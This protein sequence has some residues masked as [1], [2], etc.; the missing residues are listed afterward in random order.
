MR[1]QN[2]LPH[3]NSFDPAQK[4]VRRLDGFHDKKEWRRNAPEPENSRRWREEERETGLLGRKDR[5]KEG[6]EYRKSD[7]RTDNASV[8]EAS[9][10][11]AL[12]SSDRWHDVNSRSS[13]HDSRRDSKWSSRWGPEDRDKDSRAEKKPDADNEDSHNDT[14]FF[15]GDK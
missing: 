10:T 8:R 9:E 1:T 4:E 11:R 3:G 13:G 14:Q 7:R 5:R 12:P 15:V 2:S 6:D